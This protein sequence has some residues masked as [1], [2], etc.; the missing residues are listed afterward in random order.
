MMEDDTPGKDKVKNPPPGRQV[1][2]PIFHF[3]ARADRAA[4]F[5]CGGGIWQYPVTSARPEFTDADELIRGDF[6]SPV[7]LKEPW[8]DDLMRC[9]A[10]VFVGAS[11]VPGERAETFTAR[12]SSY[13]SW[14]SA[15]GGTNSVR[16]RTTCPSRG[17]GRGSRASL[18]TWRS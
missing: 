13:T 14:C 10:L 16:I 4:R 5:D 2:M 1:A 8:Q 17:R 15:F 11:D 9:G 12:A 18:W 3:R 7:L 6:I